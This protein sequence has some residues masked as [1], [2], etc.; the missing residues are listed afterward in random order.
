LGNILATTLPAAAAAASP[1]MALNF[2]PATL[3]NTPTILSRSPLPAG[4]IYTKMT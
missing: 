3:P 4:R 2:E 1:V